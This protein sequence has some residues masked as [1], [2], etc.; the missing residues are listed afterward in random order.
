M[1]SFT[2]SASVES[3]FVDQIE[4]RML[5][6]ADGGGKIDAP[7]QNRLADSVGHFS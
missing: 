3:V 5:P 7:H 4:I 2:Q 6:F 1:E